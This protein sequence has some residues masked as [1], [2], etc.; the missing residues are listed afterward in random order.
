MARTLVDKFNSVFEEQGCCPS[1]DDCGFSVTVDD[2]NSAELGIAGFIG[3][4]ITCR[5]AGSSSGGGGGSS[6]R[7]CAW[8]LSSAK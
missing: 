3:M 4:A 6:W 2:G 1:A 5:M 7:G 8:I